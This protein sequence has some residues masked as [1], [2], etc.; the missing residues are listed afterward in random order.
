M[1]NDPVPICFLL[2]PLSAHFLKVS[3]IGHLHLGAKSMFQFQEHCHFKSDFYR[4]P[5]LKK[6]LGPGLKKCQMSVQCTDRERFWRPG[7]SATGKLM[8]PNGV[9]L[10]S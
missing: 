4:G 2:L 9:V 3:S 5:C 10:V 1:I 8:F 6:S 7:D